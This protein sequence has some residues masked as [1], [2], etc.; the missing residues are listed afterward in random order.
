MR[1]PRVVLLRGHSANPWELSTWAHLTDRY[2]VVL[3]LTGANRY[4]VAS[5][6][7]P[8][9]PVRALRDRL[10]RGRLG[11]LGALALG[12][13]YLG[14]EDALRGADL[15][16]SAELGVWF[17]GQPARLRRRLGFRLVLTVWET[18]PFRE[19]FRAFRGRAD[20]RD[21]IAAADLF[22]AATERAR[23]CLELE[24]VP[25][26]RVDVSYPGIDVERF[27]ARRPTP[28]DGHLVVSPGRLV[29]EKGHYDVIRALARIGGD[30]RL[31]LVGTGPERE[32]LLRYAEE[33]GVRGRME[34]RAVP[35]EEMPAIFAR[36]SAVVLASL[37]IPLW[38]EQFGMVL[39]EALA[40]GAPI[41]ASTS[42][43]IPEVL[44]GSGAPLFAPG[45]WQRLA[46]LLAEGPL[47]RPPGERAAYPAQV[48]ARYS[49]HAAAERL[50]RA[51]E[52]V[53]SER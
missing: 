6:Q 27:S 47:A 44:A 15:V 7:L 8:R 50:A 13:R 28:A 12:D 51:Y 3:A 21:A 45:D 22:L 14:L 16:H 35:Y 18:I 37:P 23:S 2:D 39:A 34:I 11:D 52:R 20:R 46:R 19:T 36:A 43:A 4:D 17:S 41:L 31:L 29:W 49:T 25:P 53:L 1:R 24:G 38:E 9:E 42:G 40:A 5:L 48:V 26:G 33:L 32:R 30:T 10:P